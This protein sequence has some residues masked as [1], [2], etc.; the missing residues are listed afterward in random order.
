MIV[1]KTA[2]CDGLSSGVFGSRLQSGLSIGNVE[3][4]AHFRLGLLPGLVPSHR[5]VSRILRDRHRDDH[6]LHG[7]R[8][9]KFPGTGN[10]PD[11]FRDECGVKSCIGEWGAKS[12]PWSCAGL[13]ELTTSILGLD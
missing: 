6:R 10:A 1:W 7:T 8:A 13:V 4:L 12:T 2:M 9:G 5:Q 3:N 11:V